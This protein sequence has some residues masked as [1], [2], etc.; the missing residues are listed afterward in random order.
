[1]SETITTETSKDIFYDFYEVSQNKIV[2]WYQ[3]SNIESPYEY[4]GSNKCVFDEKKA[5]EILSDFQSEEIEEYDISDTLINEVQSSNDIVIQDVSDNSS[6]KKINVNDAVRNRVQNSYDWSE[7]DEK[8]TFDIVEQ[9]KISAKSLEKY[10][11]N[12]FVNPNIELE[13]IDGVWAIVLK[14]S[15]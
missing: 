13:K 11:K 3:A 5:K 1:M 8:E 12:R 14:K 9:E 6:L 4:S 2:D 15:N 10:L 7:E